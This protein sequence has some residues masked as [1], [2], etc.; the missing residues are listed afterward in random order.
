MSANLT[1]PQLRDMLRSLHAARQ[2]ATLE[3]SSFFPFD[4]Q[5]DAKNGEL[6]ERTRLYRETWI[7]P[8][9]DHAIGMLEAILDPKPQAKRCARSS[10]QGLHACMVPTNCGWFH[11]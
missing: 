2:A 3:R 1:R 5:G 4:P 7:I 6:R 9:I 11:S 8:Q 10:C